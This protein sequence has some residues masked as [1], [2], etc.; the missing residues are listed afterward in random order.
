MR[1]IAATQSHTNT[2]MRY[3]KCFMAA[4]Q[5][6]VSNLI[7]RGI[8]WKPYRSRID[9]SIK[10]NMYSP[11][12]FHSLPDPHLPPSLLPSMLLLPPPE[13]SPE[14]VLSSLTGGEQFALLSGYSGKKGR[15]CV[16]CECVG[17]W[18]KRNVCI[19]L[20]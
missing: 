1:C 8:R 16:S 18:G 17:G 14:K 19:S 7:S 15:W 9:F 4:M 12:S 6:F 11:P 20:C 13:N 5:R 3:A 2:W 10:K